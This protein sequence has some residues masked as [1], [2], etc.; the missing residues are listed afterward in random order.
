MFGDRNDRKA[1]VAQFPEKSGNC[2]VFY[3]VAHLCE[4]AGGFT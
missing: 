4:A 1:A 2:A 3:R